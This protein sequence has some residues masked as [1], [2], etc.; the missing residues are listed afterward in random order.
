MPKKLNQLRSGKE[1]VSYAKKE[2][3]R[4]GKEK[5]AIQWLNMRD[6]VLS[7]LSILEI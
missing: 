5:V 6:K 4:S 1:F 3:Q 2:E 7:S